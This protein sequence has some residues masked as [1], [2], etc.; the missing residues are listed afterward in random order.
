MEEIVEQLKAIVDKYKKIKK[1]SKN[2]QSNVKECL[3]ALFK[4]SDYAQVAFEFIPNLPPE[5]TIQAFVSIWEGASLDQR[6][7]LMAGLLESNAMKSNAGY[8]RIIGIIKEFIPK[9]A[10]EAM[11]LLLYTSLKITKNGKEVPNKVLAERFRKELL[12]NKFLLKLP[13]EKSELKEGEFSSLA[14][15]AVCSI[16]EKKEFTQADEE[17]L[18]DVLTWLSMAQ[19]RAF[20]GRKVIDGIEKVSKNWPENLQRK[21]LDLGLIRTLRLLCKSEDKDNKKNLPNLPESECKVDKNEEHKESP[22]DEELDAKKCLEKVAKYIEDI[23]TE[24]ECL[25]KSIKDL[26]LQLELEKQ[27]KNE[28]EKKIEELQAECHQQQSLINEMK[29][30]IADLE[31]QVATLQG[32]LNVERQAH[33]R[34]VINLKERIDRECNYVIKEFKG[35]IYDKLF[36]HYREFKS[37]KNRPNTPDIADYLKYLTERIFKVLIELGVDFEKKD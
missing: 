31:R 29:E 33:E 2:D 4:S 14:A 16:I 35:R 1:I 28:K 26:N 36:R 30:K 6:K 5:V 24:N 12:E 8:F 7:E 3:E 10:K 9:Y 18:N 34:E 21:C 32:N 20:V 25:K 13:I 23:E 37:A 17:L 22:G 19:R 11:E 15:M 27:R